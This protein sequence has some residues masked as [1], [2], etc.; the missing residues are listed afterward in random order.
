MYAVVCNFNGLVYSRHRTER[1]AKLAHD[2]TRRK[3]QSPNCGDLAY[4]V[5]VVELPARYTSIV[6][7]DNDCGCVDTGRK[8]WVSDAQ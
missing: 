6:P 2:R 8:R 3:L 5:A 7:A 1:A 4:H